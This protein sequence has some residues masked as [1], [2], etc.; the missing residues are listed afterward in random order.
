MTDLNHEKY[1]ETNRKLWNA[2]TPVHLKSDFYDMAKFRAGG[3]LLMPADLEALGDVSGKSL[4]HLQCHFGQDTL[5]WA[6]RGAK[7]T[8]VDLSDVA[9]DTARSLTTELDLQARFICCNVYDLRAHLDEQ[10]DIVYTTYGATPWLPDLEAWAQIVARFLKP[11]GTFFMAEFHPTY[12]MFNFDNL[13]IEYSYFGTEEPYEEETEGSYADHDADLRH[14]EYFW[15]HS[16]AE[17]MQPL[18]NAGLQLLEFKEYP[19]T[20][21][22]CF[23]QLVETAPGQFMHQGV[24]GKMPLMYSLKMKS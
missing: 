18:L 9:I 15:N 4:L 22:N 23:P 16:I 5:A 12:F 2:K 7:V 13:N 21:W 6:R 14:T 20:Y 11:G 1:F 10:F 24:E 3:D 8:G 17:T 19:Y